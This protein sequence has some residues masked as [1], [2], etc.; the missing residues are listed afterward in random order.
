MQKQADEMR[1]VCRTRRIA[2]Q[3]LRLVSAPLF[4]LKS[5]FSFFFRSGKKDK[6]THKIVLGLFDQNTKISKAPSFSSSLGE[7]TVT[8]D[9]RHSFVWFG[10][11]AQVLSFFCSFCVR[12]LSRSEDVVEASL[13]ARDRARA[14][15]RR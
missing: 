11:C 2:L 7:D 14:S 8:P 6:K 1:F 4:S 9:R 15:S 10:T 12:T 5:L 3:F 13:L